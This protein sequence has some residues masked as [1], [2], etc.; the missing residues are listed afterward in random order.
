MRLFIAITLD[1][2]V[3][4]ALST[5]QND[6]IKHMSKGNATAFDNF[7][8]TLRF[9]G[10]VNEK[11]A[12]K[13]KHTVD[14]TGRQFS[15]FTLRLSELGHFQKKNKKVIW[16]GVRGQLEELFEL[17]N[18]LETELETSGFLKEENDYTPHITL[19]RQAVLEESFN[20]V[21]EELGIPEKEIAVR[22][23]AL[24]ESKCV[25]GELVYKVIHK[26]DF[27]N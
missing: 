6:L 14:E 21:K 12:E 17:K 10:D 27:S 1:E 3:R 19:A 13:L 16:T 11:Q 20:D 5:I 8:I 7:H 22:S 25:E 26:K 2:Q 4:Q 24:M 23:I 15:P 9:I 18:K